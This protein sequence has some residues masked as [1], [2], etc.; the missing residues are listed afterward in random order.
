MRAARFDDPFI[1]YRFAENLAAGRGFNF[2]PGEVGAL[3][4][5]SPLYALLLAVFRVLGF[6]IPTVS[7]TIS[8]AALLAGALLLRRIAGNI[9]GLA[10]LLM[11]LLWLTVGFET[12][13]FLALVLGAFVLMDEAQ[14]SSNA[15][16]LRRWVV[17]GALF[18]LALGLR[19]DAAIP[20]LIAMVCAAFQ[21]HRFF[22][23]LSPLL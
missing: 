9:A 2:N 20:L 21:L 3:L 15:L 22:F 10:Y 4:T 1:T 23:L 11:P 5:T 8:V 7:Y 13:V 12:P 14:C 6:D 19:G 17:A 18:G 16:L